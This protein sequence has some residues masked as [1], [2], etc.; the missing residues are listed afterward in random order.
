MLRPLPLLGVSTR[1]CRLTRVTARDTFTILHSPPMSRRRNSLTSPHRNPH[2]AASNTG[3]F[4]RSGT[5]RLR[6]LVIAR[7]ARRPAEIRCGPIAYAVG[8]TYS[9]R[10]IFRSRRFRG[11][12]PAPGI[13]RLSRSRVAA[14]PL[15]RVL[16]CR[17]CPAAPACCRVAHCPNL[18]P[19]ATANMP[20]HNAIRDHPSPPPPRAAAHTPGC[21]PHARAAPSG[22]PSP[23]KIEERSAADTPGSCT[24]RRRRGLGEKAAG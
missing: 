19:H 18:I 3:A 1:Y 24:I 14:Y 4:N 16:R 21:P 9:C 22:T 20:P 13:P 15:P 5:R 8:S 6:R 11:S 17:P 10:N 12:P 2:Q 23:H 7:P